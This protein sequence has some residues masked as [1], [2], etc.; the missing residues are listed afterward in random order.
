MEYALKYQEH[1]N[2]L[3]ISNMMA[4]IPHCDEYAQAVLMPSMD[5]DALQGLQRCEAAGEYDHARD[6]AA[7]VVG[8]VRDGGRDAPP[9]TPL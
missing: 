3:I 7:L 2:G 5:P 1:L 9:A 4:S 8:T 6:E